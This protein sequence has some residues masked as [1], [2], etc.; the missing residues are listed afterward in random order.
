MTLFGHRP[1]DDIMVLVVVPI[2]MAVRRLVNGV[3]NQLAYQPI[4]H[5]E[6]LRG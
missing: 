3:I 4:I 1:N 5:E 2:F 6:L